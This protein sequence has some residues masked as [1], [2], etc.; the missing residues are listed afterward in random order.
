MAEL[1]TVVICIIL[2]PLAIRHNNHRGGRY[3]LN[4]ERLRRMQK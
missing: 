3:S 1:V 2:V 4:I